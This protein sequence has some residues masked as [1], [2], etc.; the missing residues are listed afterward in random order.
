MIRPH[1]GKTP[2]IAVSAYIDPSAVVIGDVEIGERSSVW[3]NV[4]IRGDVNTMHIGVDTN[5][6]DN[7][8]LHSDDGF[9]LV[10]GDRVTAGHS[11]V[12]HGCTIE[13]D[14]VVGIGSTILNGAKIGKGAVIAAGSVVPEGVE[15]A[16][17]M[18]V[19]GIPAKPRR[20]VNEVEQQRFREGCIHY[21][22]RARIYKQESSS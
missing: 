9:P 11:V 2:K 20:P 17:G 1:R 8:V 14:V 21:V 22:E 12:L 19:M 4:T 18:L 5:I 10:I 7:S 6:Q 3:P 15:V 16:P 13:D